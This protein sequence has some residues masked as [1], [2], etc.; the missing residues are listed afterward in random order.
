LRDRGEHLGRRPV[1]IRFDVV[2]VMGSHVEILEDA[3]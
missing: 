2:S 1:D 3:F